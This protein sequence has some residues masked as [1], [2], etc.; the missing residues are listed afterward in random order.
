ML[1]YFKQF[2]IFF[3]VLG[4]ISVVIV[5]LFYRALTPKKS[6]P[7]YNPAD[8]NPELVD[9]TVQ[10]IRKY[11]KIPAFSFVN[12]NGKIITDQTYEGK[13]YVADFFFYHLWFHL[14]QNDQQ[15]GTSAR[16]ILTRF[17]GNAVVAYR[18]SRN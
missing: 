10:F 16:S 12:Q 7:I 4:I 1:R 14:P 13:I 15:H 8:V 11:H 18:V 6:L 9:S 5:S 2:R 3:L 17:T